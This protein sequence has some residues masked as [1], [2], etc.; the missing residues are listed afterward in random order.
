MDQ[1]DDTRQAGTEVT[2]EIVSRAL[3]YYRWLMYEPGEARFTGA[4][5]D[6]L[7]RLLRLALGEVRFADLEHELGIPLDA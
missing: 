2:D 7:A 3:P 1:V 4:D 6:D 5:R